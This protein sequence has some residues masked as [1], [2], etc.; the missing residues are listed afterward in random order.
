MKT[1]MTL[2]P[3]KQT[4]LLI[5]GAD[6]KTFLQGQVTCD[7]NTLSNDI[8]TSVLAPLGAHCTHKGRVVFSFRAL[9][10]PVSIQSPTNSADA[11][12]HEQ[13]IALSV[14]STMGDV[15]LTALKKY[16][17]FSKVELS[18][19]PSHDSIIGIHGDEE[20]KRLGR[21]LLT[22]RPETTETDIIL[23]SEQHTAIHTSFGA[24]ILAA[25]DHY[26]FWLSDT[27]VAE[28]AR[29][30]THNTAHDSA[31]NTE[32]NYWHAAMI[33]SGIAHIDKNTTGEFTPHDIGYP[34]ISYAVSFKK[35]CY[36]GQEVV[37]RMHY[38]GKLK[39]HVYLFSA[40]T[41]ATDTDN[42]CLSMSGHP[43]F[44]SAKKQAVGTVI[45]HCTHA[46]QEIL[47]ASVVDTYIAEG[48]IYL[49]EDCTRALHLLTP[50]HVGLTTI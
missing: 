49:D 4:L 17:V 14:L 45:D 24:I 6:A 11:N 37:A 33:Q 31:D 47:L 13:T 44:I 48:T 9:Q 10:L 12:H 19:A 26:E 25:K 35:G 2:Y 5:K 22:A 30:L 20:A 16:S 39:K 38:L 23:P 36:T 42:Q 34:D 50:T 3:I 32:D 43:V 7:I 29:Q 21:E 41:T 1:S 15:A 28:R 40:P 46:G 18:L 8:G 27:S